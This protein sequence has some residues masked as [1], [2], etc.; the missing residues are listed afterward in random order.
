MIGDL[1]KKSFYQEFRVIYTKNIIVYQFKSS[2]FEI[3][4]FWKL[5]HL[6]YYLK[7]ILT[8]CQNALHTVKSRLFKFHTKS[9]EFFYR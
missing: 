1:S 4:K 8:L 2:L 7:S 5:Q 6:F 9:T 3:N